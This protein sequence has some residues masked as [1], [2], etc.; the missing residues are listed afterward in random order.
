MFSILYNGLISFYIIYTLIFINKKYLKLNRK[1]FFQALLFHL[2]ITFAYISFFKDKAAD[3]KTYISLSTFKGFNM[4]ELVSSDLINSIVSLLKNVLYINNFN[5]FLIFSILSFIGITLF[6]INLTKLGLEK[7]LA[8]LLLFI[9]GIHFW[10]CIVGKDS[11]ILF[12]LGIFFYFYIDKKIF[13][14]IFFIFPVFLLRPHIGFI[15]FVSILITEFILIKGKKKLFFLILLPAVFYY[16]LNISEL[17]YFFLD[18]SALSSNYLE[19]IFTHLNKYS[20]KY[21]NSDTSYSNIHFLLNISNYIIFPFEFFFTNN[22]LIVNLTILIEILTLIF[23]IYVLSKSKKIIMI[24]KK[25]FYFLLIC[26]LIYLAIV[27]QVFFNFGLNIRQ[28][29]MIAPFVIYLSFLMKNLFVYLNK[30]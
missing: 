6:T 30:K 21:I 17:R 26:C 12:F 29:W 1:L 22:S 14:S 15:F 13:I 11:L 10:T 23:I 20:I 16:V 3:Y 27:P 28:K 8:N 18:S 19:Q 9:P 7:K 24:D 25:V 2:T 5:I 4:K